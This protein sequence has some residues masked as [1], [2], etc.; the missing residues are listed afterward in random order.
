MSLFDYAILAID[1]EGG[2]GKEN[3][4]IFKD[5]DDMIFFQEKT[6]NCIVVMGS[7]TYK[8]LP[9]DKSFFSKRNTTGI[10]LT[11]DPEKMAIELTFGFIAVSENFL[12]HTIEMLQKQFIENGIDKKKVVLIGGAYY[13]NQMDKLQI[14]KVYLSVLESTSPNYESPA[15]TFV[16]LNQK[17]FSNS[18]IYRRFDNITVYKCQPPAI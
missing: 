17:V 10:V 18:T 13:Y 7:N 15:D 5:K 2:L 8:S 6:T 12:S 9:G 16:D 1:K 11:R 14:P 4:L 3:D